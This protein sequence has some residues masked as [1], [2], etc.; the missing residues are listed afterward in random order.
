MNARKCDRCGA[1]YEPYSNWNGLTNT[2]STDKKPSGIIFTIT[3][4]TNTEW[5]R[6]GWHELPDTGRKIKDLCPCC[7][8]ALLTWWNKLKNEPA[9]VY[10]PIGKK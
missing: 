7:M 6:S 10:E 5:I 3:T 8:G 9:I 2:E 1:F 4:A